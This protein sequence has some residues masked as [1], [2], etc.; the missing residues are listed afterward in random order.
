M[1][2]LSDRHM[3]PKL[4][5]VITSRIPSTKKNMGSILNGVFSP[6]YAKCTL[7]CLLRYSCCKT[8]ITTSSFVN[9]TQMFCPKFLPEQ[10]LWVFL[11]NDVTVASVIN[12][13]FG[14][15]TVE[16]I[17]QRA[18][19]VLSFVFSGRKDLSTNAIYSEIRPVY[20]DNFTQPWRIGAVRRS[21]HVQCEWKKSPAEVFW[22]FSKRLGIFSPSFTC[23]FHVPIYARLHFYLII[24]KRDEVVAY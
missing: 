13:E 24:S 17:P 19:S 7:L 8:L 21:T 10:K 3:S 4:T 6:L 15:V 23:L 11:Y 16:S 1:N 18:F 12:I 9:R 20:G 14:D 22:H 2:P 5:W